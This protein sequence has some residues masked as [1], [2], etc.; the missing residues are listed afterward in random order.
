MRFAEGQVMYTYS[1]FC[2]NSSIHCLFIGENYLFNIQY[3]KADYTVDLK[4]KIKKL[5]RSFN[6]IENILNF[7]FMTQ[8]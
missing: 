2:L 7:Y 8:T 3:K 4:L 1:L 6:V 5:T